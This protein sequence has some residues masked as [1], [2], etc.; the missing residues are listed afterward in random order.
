M[1]DAKQEGKLTSTFHT[2]LGQDY[3][4]KNQIGID[5]IIKPMPSPKIGPFNDA[6]LKKLVGDLGNT[7]LPRNNTALWEVL[8]GSNPLENT[9][10]NVIL[11]PE[12]LSH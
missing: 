10:T 1:S 7:P 8:I 2:F 9:N 12:I 4:L 6:Y 3:L 11:L 5:E